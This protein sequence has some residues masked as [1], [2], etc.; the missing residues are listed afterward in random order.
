MTGAAATT[1]DPAVLVEEAMRTFDGTHGYTDDLIRAA[2]A[3]QAILNASDDVRRQCILIVAR[4]Q[5]RDGTSLLGYIA[6]KRAGLTLDDIE[7]ILPPPLSRQN[8]HGL[9]TGARRLAAL[10]GQIEATWKSLDDE[11][12]A[13]S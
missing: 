6:R 9:W 5:H 8:P 12:S 2:P 1:A 7:A 10:A 13:S 11:E 3:I 4:Q